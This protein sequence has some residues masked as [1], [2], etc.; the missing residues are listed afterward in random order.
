M[1]ISHFPANPVH[2]ALYLT[3]ILEPK[4]SYH[5]VKNASYS[6]DWAYKIAGLE[7][8]SQHPMV[9]AV[10]EFRARIYGQ[11]VFKK[12][13]ITPVV[14]NDLVYRYFCIHHPSLYHARTVALCLIAYPGFLSYDELAVFICY[15]SSW[16]HQDIYRVVKNRSVSGWGLVAHQWFQFYYMS[17]KSFKSIC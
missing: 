15:F 1:D 11:H 13:P 7:V 3:F 12:E 2:V 8:P 10:K 5:A 6:I 14:L 17:F 16:L 9:L 4:E